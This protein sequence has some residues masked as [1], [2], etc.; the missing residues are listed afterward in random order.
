MPNR[1]SAGRRRS[2]NSP[3]S[4]GTAFARTLATPWGDF[5]KHVRRLPSGSCMPLYDS[6]L[7]GP[8]PEQPANM[9][10]S[11]ARIERGNRMFL[12]STVSAPQPQ[13]FPTNYT[14]SSKRRVMKRSY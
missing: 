2:R 7:W 10:I 6:Q 13:L 3:T 8:L 9:T 1:R 14:Q 12:T 11:N 4:L 5:D